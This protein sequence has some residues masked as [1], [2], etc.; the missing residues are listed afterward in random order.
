MFERST[1]SFENCDYEPELKRVCDEIGIPN[2]KS[3]Q[4]STIKRILLQQTTVFIAPT[5]Y[6]KSICYQ[7]PAVLYY[8]N[9]KSLAIVICPLV[10]LIHD[11][12]NSLPSFVKAA[13]LHSG[14]SKNERDDILYRISKQEF[15]I[16]FL[17]PEALTYGGSAL[18]ENFPQIS[19]VCID[20]IHCLSS[21]SHNFRPAYLRVTNLLGRYI[22]ITCFLGLTATINATDLKDVLSKMNISIDMQKDFV[23]NCFSLSENVEMR[24]INTLVEFL[25]S[26]LKDINNGGVLIFCRRRTTT[27]YV[28]SY[29]RSKLRGILTINSIDSYHAG[30]STKTRH[31]IQEKFIKNFIKILASTSAF[32]MGLNKRNIRLVVHYDAPS[33]IE[34]Y[35]QEIGRGG[36]DGLSYESIV[37][38]DEN[39]LSEINCI[40]S[41][42]YKNYIDRNKISI[43]VNRLLSHPSL[44]VETTAHAHMI[45]INKNAL[46]QELDINLESIETLIYFIECIIKKKYH[47]KLYLE[48]I[49]ANDYSDCKLT[50]YSSLTKI[51]DLFTQCK[52][53]AYYVKNFMISETDNYLDINLVLLA[54]YFDTKTS[55]ILKNM[56]EFKKKFNHLIFEPSSQQII[57]KVSCL[58]SI[59]N[60]H[61]LSNDLH[62]YTQ[63]LTNQMLS[64]ID[65]MFN[66]L[67]TISQK[68]T[69]LE[70][71]NYIKNYFDIEISQNIQMSIDFPSKRYE[72][73]D[74]F[75]SHSLNK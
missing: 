58:T 42:V 61:Q 47:S 67:Y 16:L 69:P 44:E 59:E 11:Q 5:N 43:L 10:S 15:T 23:I 38:L 66:T 24:V 48:F 21:W 35:V 51:K 14:L 75:F 63:Q 4:Y 36:R 9:F 74:Y 29:L 31:D 64:S 3:Q 50:W 8:R 20:E 55:N 40:K 6:G 52:P 26:K 19:F 57:L 41:S 2:L 7:I 30:L 62:S 53:L 39:I 25:G 72:R 13:S 32:G 70:L 73:F 49:S 45:G 33:S 22:G 27:E 28:S 65:N 37:L 18:F 54:N 56:F 46:I 1:L 12:I 68:S 71:K 60:Q 17:A 34:Q